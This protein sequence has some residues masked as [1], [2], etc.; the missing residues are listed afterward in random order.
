LGAIEVYSDRGAT[1]YRNF[2]H[3]SEP[4]STD[5]RLPSLARHAALL[6]H[7]RRCIQDEVTPNPGAAEGVALMEM[8]DAI[9]KSA[10]TGRSVGL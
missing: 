6:R 4:R 3:K 5:L 2:G 7:F 1:L 10:R 9:Y 8:V